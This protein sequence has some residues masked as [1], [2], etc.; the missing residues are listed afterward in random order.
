MAAQRPSRRL[1]FS[2][3]FLHTLNGTEHGSLPSLTTSNRELVSV[4]EVRIEPKDLN[5][6]PLTPHSVTLPTLPLTIFGNNYYLLLTFICIFNLVTFLIII[7][8]MSLL[9]LYISLSKFH[10]TS[11]FCYFCCSLVFCNIVLY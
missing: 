6:G 9:F 2:R 8:F 5:P 10:F 11:S 7:M 4:L 3:L 1:H